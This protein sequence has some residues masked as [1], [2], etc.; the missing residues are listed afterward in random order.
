MARDIDTYL[1]KQLG[2]FD[3]KNFVLVIIFIICSSWI[4]DGVAW[5]ISLLFLAIF[6]ISFANYI[7]SIKLVLSIL[8]FIYIYNKLKKIKFPI[9][10]NVQEKEADTLNGFKGLI[11]FLSTPSKNLTSDDIRN[12][13]KEN[14]DKPNLGQNNFNWENY[15]LIIKEFKN[16]LEYI[17]VIV[18]KDSSKYEDVFKDYIN[19]VVDFKGKIIF[20]T[21]PIDFDDLRSSI[22]QINYS[23]N[24][25]IKEHGLKENEIIIDITGGQKIQSA[26]GA[27]YSS[28]YD[29][30]FCYLSTN[31]RKLKIFD[32]II[33]PEN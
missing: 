7:E 4:A 26:A 11:I 18:S 9:N 13:I 31:K 6:N 5:F 20:S 29:R 17:Y 28:S 16:N 14:K 22:D 2:K 25:L 3:L 24:K 1:Y 27:F 15:Y 23:Y 32:A 33:E 12:L 10:F 8:F 30:Y 19:Q 21:N